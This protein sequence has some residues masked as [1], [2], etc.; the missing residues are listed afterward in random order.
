MT[1]D[2]LQR[3]E[4]EFLSRIEALQAEV[5]ELQRKVQAIREVRDML[6]EGEEP[7]PVLPNTGPYVG[8]SPAQAVRALLKLQQGRF[9]TP[10]EIAT[11]LKEGGVE[12]KAS[13]F[14]NGVNVACSRLF[15]RGE[16]QSRTNGAGRRT[17][18]LEQEPISNV[19]TG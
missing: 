4:K 14:A 19:T 10:S 6:A 16:I 9:M 18:G 7:T 3:K 2:R 17:F 15:D 8:M 11:E 13:S 12:T 5:N 1:G